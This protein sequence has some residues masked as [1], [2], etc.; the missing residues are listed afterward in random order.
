[1][2]SWHEFQGASIDP[3]GLEISATSGDEDDLDEETSG[4]LTDFEDW[5]V[6]NF[7]EMEV[8]ILL[9][10]PARD[11]RNGVDAS[12]VDIKRLMKTYEL[13]FR[14]LLVTH[15]SLRKEVRAK[16]DAAGLAEVFPWKA[17]PYSDPWGR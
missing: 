15:D 14:R 8:D 13:T 2:Q 17:T 9:S 12:H 1:M 11:W 16:L 3:I 4:I 10:M 6:A 5:L 7:S